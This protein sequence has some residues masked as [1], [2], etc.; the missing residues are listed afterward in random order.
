MDPISPQTRRF[1]QTHRFDSPQQLALKSSGKCPDVD[2]AFALTQISGRQ[3]IKEKIPSWYELDDLIYPVSLS[4]EQASSELTACYKASLV[5]GC[6]LVDLTGGFGVDCAFLADRFDSVTYVE[7][8]A[9]LCEIALSNF[10]TL[11]KNNI[12]VLCRDAVSYL[13]HMSP[14]DCIYLDPARRSKTGRKMVSIADCVPDA[15][16]ILP[17]LLEKSGIVLIKLSPMLDISLA[18]Q[19]LPGTRSVHVVSAEN[20]CRELLFLIEKGYAGEP[21]IQCVNLSSTG[22]TAEFRFLK[23]QEKVL[24]ISYTA[25]VENYLYE[26]NASLLKAGAYK[27]AAQQ[28]LIRKL[29]PDSHLYTS[30]HDIPNFPGRVFKVLFVSSFNA[31]ELKKNCKNI[32]AAHIS[33]RN[34]PD[35]AEQLRKRLQLKDGGRFYLFATTLYNGKKVI[36][37]GVREQFGGK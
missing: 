13:Q 2:L 5:Q 36:I 3:A 19:S 24:E 16:L 28:Y 6:S 4:L 26:P 9:A 17:L 18:L 1:I 29:H 32:P 22:D 20:E 37:G 15:G 8:Q 23:S 30:Q 25:E 33:V 10:S 35:T 14:V 27:S 12:R 11:Q 21:Q 7:E 34:F 31:V